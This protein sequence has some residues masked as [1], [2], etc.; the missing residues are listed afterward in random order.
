MIAVHHLNLFLWPSTSCYNLRT[1]VV[2]D[3]AQY[4]ATLYSDVFRSRNGKERPI[5][6]EIY[7]AWDGL[8]DATYIFT[9]TAVSIDVV[10]GPSNAGIGELRNFDLCTDSGAFSERTLL[11][12]A[13]VLSYLWSSQDALSAEA[14]HILD[15]AW[16][17][18]RGRVVHLS[19][20]R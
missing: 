16:L 11:F 19:S 5:L 12:D 9:G 15:R 2:L 6:T 7:P 18:L 10:D 14:Q 8:L 17:Q 1:Y 13:Y 4:A 3:G 20:S